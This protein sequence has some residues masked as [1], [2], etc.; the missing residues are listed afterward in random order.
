MSLSQFFTYVV[1]ADAAVGKSLIRLLAE[2]HYRYKG[3]SPENR[4]RH[5]LQANA[6]PFFVLTPSN[7]DLTQLNNFEF[8]ID[9][10]QQ[11]DGVILLVSSLSVNLDDDADNLPEVKAMRQLEQLVQQ[12]SQHLILRVGEL[13]SLTSDDFATR[14]LQDLRNNDV[15]TMNDSG[16][17]APTPV[18]DVAD[19]LMA[20]MKQCN[21]TDQLWGCYSFNG[22]EPTTAYG[23]AESLLAEAGQYEDF[24][25]T[26]LISDPEGMKPNILIPLAEGQGLFHSFGIKSKPWRS[27]LHELIKRYYQ[28]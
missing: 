25:S 15:V 22:L 14:L 9:I 7:S 21:C 2:Q 19:V 16:R 8:W 26:S 1:G 18:S 17:F 24:Q 23:F 5:S 11:Q 6:R 10:A 12:H 13:F 20:I 27:G 3:I 28:S 4:E